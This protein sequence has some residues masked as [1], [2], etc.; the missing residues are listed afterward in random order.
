MMVINGGGECPNKDNLSG[1]NPIDHHDGKEGWEIDCDG[2]YDEECK[3][4]AVCLDYS[5][6]SS[7]SKDNY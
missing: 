5:L 6:E 4:Y 3:V 7:S 2:K 1:S